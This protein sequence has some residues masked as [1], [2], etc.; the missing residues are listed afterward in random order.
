VRAE[1]PGSAV[2]AGVRL[3]SASVMILLP[4][5]VIPKI[6]STLEGYIMIRKYIIAIKN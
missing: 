2:G 5:F 1:V 6:N 3:R 4:I